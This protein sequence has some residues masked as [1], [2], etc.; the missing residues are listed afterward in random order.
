MVFSADPQQSQR[1]EQAQRG[2]AEVAREHALEWQAR[3]R[4]SD[5]LI[6]D[7]C[8][9]CDIASPYADSPSAQADKSGS[10]HDVHDMDAPE[11]PA[12]PRRV[13][14]SSLGIADRLLR[15]EQGGYGTPRDRVGLTSQFLPRNHVGRMDH[16]HRPVFCGTFS[17]TGTAYM[18]A[19]QDGT[20]RLYDARRNF[21][22]AKEIQADDVGWSIID[23]DY[24]PDQQFIIYSTWSN[25]VHLWTATETEGEDLHLELDFSPPEAHFCLFSIKFSH[26]SAEIVGGGS[27][28]CIYVYGAPLPSAAA[29]LTAKRPVS[30][31]LLRCWH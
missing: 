11:A 9:H 20:I 13:P 29:S 22:L 26:D 19:C 31:S 14:P 2:D 30:L 16:F 23:T 7:I 6:S 21:R 25:Y 24:S 5:D 12:E 3:M 17:P 1:A 27:D 18:A 15:R 28:H 4:D 8:S 10:L